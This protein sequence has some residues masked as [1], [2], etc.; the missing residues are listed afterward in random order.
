M[1]LTSVSSFAGSCLYMGRSILTHMFNLQMVGQLFTRGT[2]QSVCV[3][4]SFVFIVF[5]FNNSNKNNNKQINRQSD[6]YV[7]LQ[8]IQLKI[9]FFRNFFSVQAAFFKCM[10]NK[11]VVFMHTET[12]SVLH[13]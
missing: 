11:L 6:K 2:C 9:I 13:M 10:Q 4:H 8:L 3:F 7:T 5:F 1:N 12:C